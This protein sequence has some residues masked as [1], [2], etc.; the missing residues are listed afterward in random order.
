MISEV[1]WW[2]PCVN[3]ASASF[4][5]TTSCRSCESHMTDTKLVYGH[6]TNLS[7]A[8]SNEGSDRVTMLR[9]VRQVLTE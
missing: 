6:V 2:A 7:H 9:I 5:D 1:G 4:S 8:S 3:T